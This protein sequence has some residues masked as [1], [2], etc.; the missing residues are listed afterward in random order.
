MPARAL[1]YPE[2]FISDP[3]FLAE[4][5]LYWDRLGCIVPFPDFRQM[6]WHEDE[7]M[8]KL[9]HEAHEHFITCAPPSDEQK[10]LAHDRISKLFADHEA[11]EWCRPQNLAPQRR[12]IFS[13]S[14]LA[15]ATVQMLQDSGWARPALKKSNLELQTIYDAAANLVLGALADA[16]SS[17]D[18]PAVTDDPGSYSASCNLL[19]LELGASAGVTIKEGGAVKQSR[20]ESDFALLLAKVPRLRLTP[21][22]VNTEVLRRILD[23]RLDSGLDEQ[24]RLFQSKVDSYLGKLRT[25]GEVE[26][27][28]IADGFADELKTDQDRLS[29]ELRRMGVEALFSKEGVVAILIGLAVGVINPGVGLAV[30]L[31]GQLAAYHYKRQ[32]TS[33]QHWSSWM[34][35]SAAY[36]LTIW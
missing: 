5:L 6:P 18:M 35:S 8:R 26:R 16:C 4:S 27:Q 34:F 32:D 22:K 12:T 13:A 17:P 2:W 36:N 19:L 1:Y 7:E 21:E 15:P 31:A 30:G 23:A 33:N 25:A 14:K 29:R 11:P 28:L 20:V 3:V 9:M 10:Q 24:R